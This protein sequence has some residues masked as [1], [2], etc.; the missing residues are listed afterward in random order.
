M[1]E[2]ADLDAS[3]YQKHSQPQYGRAQE[4][5]KNLRISKSSNILDVGCGYGNILAELYKVVP[6]G[7]LVGIDASADMI[8]LAQET[9][10][11][12]HF[13]NL[14]FQNIK[15]EEMNFSESFDIVICFS[16]L[17]WIRDPRR[18][19][20]RMCKAL[21]PGGTLLIL[22]Y[23]KESG[24]IT[25]LEKTLKEYPDFFSLSAARTMLSAKEYEEAL[26]SH[27]MILEEFRLEWRHSNYKTPEDLKSYLKGWLNCYVPLPSPLQESFLNKAIL[28]SRLVSVTSKE[29]T[30][31]YQ[32]LAIRANKGE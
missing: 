17:L 23:L 12:K 7:R 20:D 13:S 11:K 25:F 6:K 1:Q 16:C 31:P 21:K 29:I 30:I 28:K 3:Y 15:A 22:T 10:P 4:L 27:R 5:L 2:D 18:A 32:V 26:L 8:H 14:E 9:Y 24:Y 19:I